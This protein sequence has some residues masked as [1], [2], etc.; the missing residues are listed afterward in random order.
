MNQSDLLTA[1]G[2]LA[3][4]YEDAAVM[5]IMVDAPDKVYVHRG[6][7]LVDMGV[8][9]TNAAAFQDTISSLVQLGH[10]PANPQHPITEIR[11]PDGARIVV[12]LPPTA[13]DGPHLVIHKY[14]GV[15]VTWDKLLEWGSI[16]QTVLDFLMAAIRGRSNIL[17]AGGTSSGKTTVANLMAGSIPAE[18]RVILVEAAYEMRV[19][20]PRCLALEA[21]GPAGITMTEL[22][23]AAARLSPDWLIIGEMTGPEALHALEVMSRGVNGM[24]TIHADSAEDALSRLES[25]CL[26]AN[27]GL[28]LGQ[29]RQ[30]IAS[31][32]RLVTYQAMVQERGRGRRTLTQIVELRGVEND[33]YLLQPLFRYN[34]DTATTESTGHQPTFLTG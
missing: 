27:M 9:F 24:M 17:I 1:L 21:G 4:L 7:E 31:A 18:Q 2:P 23:D 32:V 10:L 8:K 15:G 19:Q 3:E 25:L 6:G 34:P 30:L 22:L 33:R 26:M 20:H 14:P 5:T 11:L 12:V 16:T 13:V 28:G 29:I